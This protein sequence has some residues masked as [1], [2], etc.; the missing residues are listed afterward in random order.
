MVMLGHVGAAPSQ[1]WGVPWGVPGTLSAA[2]S[3][4]FH[5]S[6]VQKERRGLLFPFKTRPEAEARSLAALFVTLQL[7]KHAPIKEEDSPEGPLAGGGGV[8]R[9]EPRG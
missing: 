3:R 8:Q 1:G 5:P 9:A 4:L 2:C 6:P 7:C